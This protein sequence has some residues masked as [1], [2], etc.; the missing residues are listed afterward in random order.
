M[1]YCY[2]DLLEPQHMIGELLPQRPLLIHHVRSK[3]VGSYFFFFA[4]VPVP[5][6]R[7]PRGKPP[8]FNNRSIRVSVFVLNLRLK[9]ANKV[10]P[11]L[12]GKHYFIIKCCLKKIYFCYD[13]PFRQSS[14]NLR[15][16]SF[17]ILNNSMRIRE[18]K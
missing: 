3:W 5:I 17:H 18:E 6:T 2:Y 7:Y 9:L 1:N 14:R 15:D 12:S 13:Y 10:R 16:R 4:S 8:H 11:I